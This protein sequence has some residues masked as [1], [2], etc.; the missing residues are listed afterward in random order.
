MLRFL[1]LAL[2][3]G[4]SALALGELPKLNIE[5]NR[6]LS[7][8]ATLRHYAGTKGGPPALEHVLRDFRDQ[9]DLLG[10]PAEDARGPALILGLLDSL[11]SS[12]SSAQHFKSSAEGL[13]ETWS[14]G[15][16]SRAWLLRTADILIRAEEAYNANADQEKIDRIKKAIEEDKVLRPAW[17]WIEEKLGI[18]QSPKVLS[19]ALVPRFAA[20]GA[21]TLRSRGGVRILISVDSFSG[22]ALTEALLHEAIHACE[23]SEGESSVKVLTG[24]RTAET[25]TALAPTHQQNLPHTLYFLAAAEAVRQSGHKDHRD[26]GETT[27]VYKRGLD[28][29][30]KHLAPS[31]SDYLSGKIDRAE[32][33][34]RAAAYRV[35]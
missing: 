14:R 3:L 28:P 6:F 10:D 9:V 24:I 31:W 25:L 4:G 16:M 23:A 15:A 22:S 12:S 18:K 1:V 27:G 5:S 19:I 17:A 2:V 20:P 30:R 32:F 11:A 29:Y 26:V 21:V 33:I 8:Y 34:R 7:A 13:P 35:G